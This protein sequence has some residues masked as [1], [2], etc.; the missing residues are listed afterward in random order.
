VYVEKRLIQV[1]NYLNNTLKK[2]I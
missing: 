1:K 2:R